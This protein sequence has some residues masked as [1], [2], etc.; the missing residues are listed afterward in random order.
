MEFIEL[1]WS[2]TFIFGFVLFMIM[3]ISIV[4]QHI[5]EYLLSKNAKEKVE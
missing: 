1:L 5:K 2:G 4:K 3:M